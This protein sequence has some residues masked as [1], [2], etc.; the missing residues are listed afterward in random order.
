[1]EKVKSIEQLQRLL[2]A[3]RALRQ[4]YLTNFF[5]DP[6]KHGMWIMK[7]DCWFK[8]MGATL[9]IVKRSS[10]FW[11]VFY[12]TTT[13]EELKNNL[14]KFIESYYATKMMFDIVG[15]DV[16]CQP[17]VKLF[18]DVGCQ[19][20]TS[21][22]RM[23]RIAEP[24]DYIFDDT[25]RKATYIDIQKISML[26][27]T[28]FDAHTEQ[29]PYDE[30]LIEYAHRGHILVCE[31]HNNIEGFLIYE[32]NISTLY[33]RYWF[34]HPKFRDRK[35]GSRMLRRFFEE[36]R[37]TKRQMFWVICSNDNAIKR[38]KHYGFKEENMYEFILTAGGEYSVNQ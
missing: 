2:T 22:V 30:E 19:E 34:T 33:L 17:I 29:I 1:M 36:G 8:R 6:V 35:V 16:Q 5:L 4:G 25:I 10:S 28:Y 14:Y 27:H 24:L 37:N 20:A 23:T 38:Y 18:R 13:L 21:L 32:Q 12:C 31:E 9:F 11:N 7:G 26:L 3:I 15:R